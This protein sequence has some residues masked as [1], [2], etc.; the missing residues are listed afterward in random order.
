MSSH[1]HECCQCE[2]SDTSSSQ[3]AEECECSCCHGHR[4]DVPEKK[5][6][7]PPMRYIKKGSGTVVGNDD[8]EVTINYSMKFSNIVVETKMNYTFTIGADIDQIICEGL[9]H[10]VEYMHEGDI[11]VSEVMPEFAFGA[12]GDAT[13]NIPPNAMVVFEVELVSLRKFPTMFDIV[14]EEIYPFALKKKEEGNAFLKQQKVTRAVRAYQC[15]LEYL[16]EDYRIPRSVGND[17]FTLRH[18]LH[19]NLCVTYLKLQKYKLV[20]VHAS[21]VIKEDQTN[22]KALLRRGTAYY[23]LDKMGKA[24]EDLES[25]LDYYPDSKDAENLLRAVRKKIAEDLMRQKNLCKK[26]F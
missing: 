11:C 24:K 18:I 6:V 1:H 3:E 17:V 23:Y 2:G 14:S 13:R 15:G 16:E 21:I 12:T 20:V 19:T 25:T 8:S 4:N 22:W 5:M 26:M 9:E 7:P 10:M